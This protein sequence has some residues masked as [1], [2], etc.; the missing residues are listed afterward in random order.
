MTHRL[1]CPNGIV[2]V[3]TDFGDADYYTAAMCGV[4]LSIS[5]SLKI[6][7]GPQ[8][9]RAQDVTG[10]AY[11]INGLY[12]TF[13][14]GTV[15]LVVVD[16]GVGSSRRVIACRV[17]DQVLVAPDNGVLALVCHKAKTDV[18]VRC[19]PPEAGALERRSVWRTE[20]VEPSMC[21]GK[22]RGR[23]VAKVTSRTSNA[24]DVRKRPMLQRIAQ[25]C[26][27]G[28]GVTGVKLIGAL[29]EP[30][31]AK[32]GSGPQSVRPS[33]PTVGHKDEAWPLSRQGQTPRP[34]VARAD[35]FCAETPIPRVSPTVHGRDIF[36]PLAARLA[37][38]HQAF[39]ELGPR[40]QPEGL[41]AV[42]PSGTWTGST[43]SGR[44][45][46]ADGFGNL[47]TSI[48]GSAVMPAEDVTIRIGDSTI[49]RFVHFYAQAAPG[50]LVALVGSTGFLEISVVQGSASEVLGVATG[51]SVV[52][53]RP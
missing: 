14:P 33:V 46:H 29:V 47:I 11:V 34:S 24:A 18:E 7:L 27:G 51:A 19:F 32:G 37:G 2:T 52:C 25:A 42:L 40:V 10:A 49:D 13:P 21:A 48:P 3:T 6:V 38:G 30:G 9:L 28:R 12:E 22:A 26:M 17:C 16:P 35:E 8:N 43:L 41:P 36:A 39:E 44:V 53:R 20:T 23:G 50:S 31:E 15:H 4:M 1:F 45:I 5:G